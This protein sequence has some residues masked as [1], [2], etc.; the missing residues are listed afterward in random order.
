MSLYYLIKIIIVLRGG[1]WKREK[2]RVLTVFI[3]GI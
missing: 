2:G 3:F 1:R